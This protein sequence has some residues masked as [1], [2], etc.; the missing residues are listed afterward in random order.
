MNLI[1]DKYIV[2]ELQEQ[3]NKSITLETS[4]TEAE[5]SISNISKAYPYC[6]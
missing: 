3:K 6:S 4:L 1:S 5:T 2:K